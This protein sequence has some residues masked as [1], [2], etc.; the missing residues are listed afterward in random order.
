MARDFEDAKEEV[1][2]DALE[3]AEPGEQATAQTQGE[4]EHP[5]GDDAHT[6]GTIGT[7]EQD[8]SVSFETGHDKPN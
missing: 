7:K 4:I 5:H 8:G 2:E 3:D 1:L 6:T